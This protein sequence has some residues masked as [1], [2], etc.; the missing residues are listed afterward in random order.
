MQGE[1]MSKFRKAIMAGLGAALAA[2]VSAYAQDPHTNWQNAVI[3]AV[4]AGITVG[5]ATYGVPNV[6]PAL[7]GRDRSSG[8][9]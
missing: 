1:T 2:L 8:T 9:R 4:I 6:Q 7:S 3:M 5:S